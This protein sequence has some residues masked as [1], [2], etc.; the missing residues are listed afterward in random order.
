MKIEY[1][2]KQK[3]EMLSIALLG[4][5][6]L[7]AVFILVKITSFFTDSARAENVVKTALESINS[8]SVGVEQYFTKDRNLAATLTRN[9]LFSPAPPKENP[10]KE[11][12][13][14]FGNQALIDDNWY[15]EGQTIG[16]AKIVAIE[17]MQVTVEWDGR[18]TSFRPL[19]ASMP[20][21]QQSDRATARAGTTRPDSV[22][23]NSP[24]GQ[25]PG[26]MPG[27]RMGMNFQDMRTNF[28]N[29]SPAERQRLREE[30]MQRF[31]GNRAFGGGRGGG[32]FGGGRGGGGR[33]GG[34][35]GGGN[36]G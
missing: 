4:L 34:G 10:V 5:S 30:M 12:R 20:E 35:R 18:Q 25:M 16:D 1:L 21:P 22:I 23:L 14:I 32:G 8:E 13:A 6:A 9:N 26:Q 17:P 3:K 28:Q 31:Q 19:D 7:L 33:G 29:M 24:T 36:G 2:L 27:G 11:V 15:S